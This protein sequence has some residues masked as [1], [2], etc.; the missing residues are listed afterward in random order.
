MSIKSF[1]ELQALPY[2]YKVTYAKALWD[3]INGKRH[4]WAS[5][6]WVWRYEF[7]RRENPKHV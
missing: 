3:S 1:M 5:N 6:P 4:P 7:R 2:E